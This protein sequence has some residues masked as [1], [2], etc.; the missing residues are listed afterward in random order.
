MTEKERKK[1][2]REERKREKERKRKKALVATLEALQANSAYI[3]A[4]VWYSGTQKARL[5]SQF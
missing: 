1:E 5:K 2:G 4:K 3:G